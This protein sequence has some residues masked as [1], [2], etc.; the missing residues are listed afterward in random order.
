MAFFE[1]IGNAI[2]NTGNKVSSG[3]KDL[4]QKTKLNAEISRLKGETT[5]RYTALGEMYYAKSTGAEPAN[6]LQPVMEEIG[7]LLAQIDEKE[8]QVAQIDAD[9]EARKREA[10]ARREEERARKAAESGQAP[11]G[12]APGVR[13]ANCGAEISAG[14]KFCMI[15]G[16]AVQ[17]APSPVPEPVEEPKRQ[18]PECGAP[19]GESDLFCMSC[20][21]KLKD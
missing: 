20:G 18:C 2:K 8:K 12:P 16:T 4:T 14:S 5:R 6:D 19:Y 11:Q 15:C 3:A 21:H 10:E 1:N 7:G 13:C 17:T 9:A